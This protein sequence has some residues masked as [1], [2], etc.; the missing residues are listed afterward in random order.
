MLWLPKWLQAN[1]APE[2]EDVH[3]RTLLMLGAAAAASALLPNLPGH[4]GGAMT[5][6]RLNRG[7]VAADADAY[8]AYFRQHMY[9]Q[10]SI[11]RDQM[12]MTNI[13][14]AKPFGALVREATQ[15]AL[16]ETKAEATRAGITLAGEADVDAYTGRIVDALRAN[17]PDGNVP[18]LGKQLVVPIVNPYR[19]QWNPA[20]G[21]VL[22]AMCYRWNIDGER[23]TLFNDPGEQERGGEP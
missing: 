2:P 19:G 9:L 11:P 8:V 12:L 23:R 18:I 17:H 6:D 15:H 20:D 5:L 22:P 10:V 4:R 14:G 21:R 16:D 7:I 13:E 3:R 1:A